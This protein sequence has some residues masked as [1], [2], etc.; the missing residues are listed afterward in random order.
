MKGVTS[1][2]FCFLDSLENTDFPL[3]VGL[4]AGDIPHL[5]WWASTMQCIV[6]N[7]VQIPHL[8]LG[9]GSMVAVAV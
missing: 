5:C 4:L 9:G 3:A 7:C 8:A 6:V 2:S 1:S